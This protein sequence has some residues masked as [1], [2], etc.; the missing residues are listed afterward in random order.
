MYLRTG[1]IAGDDFELPVLRLQTG[2]PHL[3]YVMLGVEHRFKPA[4]S[5][6]YQLGLV[7]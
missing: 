4:S 5:A 2:A 7:P 6:H 1:S 3:V